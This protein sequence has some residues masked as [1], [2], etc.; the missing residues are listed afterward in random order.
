MAERSI[1]ELLEGGVAE[2]AA[3]AEPGAA[4]GAEGAPAATPD[5]ASAAVDP[6]GGKG[7]AAEGGKAAPVDPALKTADPT[8][9]PDKNAPADPAAGGAA[10]T[11]PADKDTNDG[12]GPAPSDPRIK[13]EEEQAVEPPVK[14]SAEDKSA[15]AGLAPEAKRLVA[16]LERERTAEFTRK[17]QDLAVQRRSVEGVMQ[18]IEPRK[19]AWAMAGVSP[20]MAVAQLLAYS[21]FADRD[22]AGF[23][24]HIAQERGVDLNQLLTA[25]AAPTDPNIQAVHKDISEIR[26]AVEGMQTS[27]AAA[28][29]TRVQSEIEAFRADPAHAFFDDVREDMGRV[30][31]AGLAETLKEAYDLACYRNP[32]VRRRI[33]DSKRIAADTEAAEARRVAEAKARAG[34]VTGAPAHGSQPARQPAKSIRESLTRQLNA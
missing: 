18:A 6:A 2:H 27:A 32:D 24:R 14:W 33:E 25:H 9:Q 23:I 20:E 21:D 28:H 17:T 7:P 15:F 5:P 19:Q 34:G 3:G 10:K 4:T 1:R 8:S 31:Q 11:A 29:Q 22:F 30:F 16:K 12:K 13:S 26:T